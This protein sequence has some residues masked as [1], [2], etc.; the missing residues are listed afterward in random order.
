M[1]A[2]PLNIVIDTRY[3]MQVDDGATVTCRTCGLAW[4]SDA[5]V[6]PACPSRV[7]AQ[8]IPAGRLS[9]GKR[10]LLAVLVAGLAVNA[11]LGALIL[12]SLAR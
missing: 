6:R 8:A 5:A 10:W 4:A 1:K 3:C 2:E 12:W 9:R 11:L 7:A